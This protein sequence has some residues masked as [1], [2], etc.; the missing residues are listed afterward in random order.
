MSALFVESYLCEVSIPVQ[1]L[2]GCPSGSTA[3]NMKAEDSSQNWRGVSLTG[4]TLDTISKEGAGLWPRV[5]NNCLFQ[6]PE[7]SSYIN[8]PSSMALYLLKAI[9]AYVWRR[10]AVKILQPTAVYWISSLSGFSWRW[11]GE[12]SCQNTL[13]KLQSDMVA[14][15]CTDPH[16]TI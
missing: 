1:V 15:T 10:P 13:V 14:H 6:V 7:R 12:N 16:E 5:L 8:F 11:D 9:T 3:V 2:S 4:L